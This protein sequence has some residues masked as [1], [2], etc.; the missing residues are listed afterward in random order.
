MEQKFKVGDRVR[1]TRDLPDT[2]SIHPVNLY[3]GDEGV[4]VQHPRLLTQLGFQAERWG[5]IS[6]F[7][8]VID[9]DARC[10]L[11]FCELV[12][13]SFEDKFHRVVAKVTADLEKTR[14]EIIKDIEA[15]EATVP[16]VRYWGACGE[17]G[18]E[19]E[20]G[21]WTRLCAAC[22]SKL[23]KRDTVEISAI[24]STAKK[25]DLLSL[26]G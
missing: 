23:P 22:L 20:L 5:D 6:C 11:D 24:P 17:C 8:R 7:F 15:E 26:R 12:E 18:K 1:L 19:T 10:V 2:A 13:E 4:V 3:K 14:Q 21:V 9:E 25:T 16:S